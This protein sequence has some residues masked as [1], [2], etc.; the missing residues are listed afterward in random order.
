MADR[1]ATIQAMLRE[2]PDD[3]FLHY[4]L[5]LEYAGN[6]DHQKA[7]EQFI[8]CTR[9]DEGYL[10][11]YVEA[12]KCLRSAG[13]LAAARERLAEAL[14]LAAMQGQEHTRDHIRQLLEAIPK[15]T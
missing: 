14:E 10:A 3:V 4:S 5:G 11:A 1:I 13:D 6:G 2:N 7:T 8:E 15:G 9:L 12:G